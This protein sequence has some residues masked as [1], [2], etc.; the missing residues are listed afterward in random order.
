MQ[1]SRTRSRSWPIPWVPTVWDGKPTNN[2]MA[3]LG[4]SFI[5]NGQRDVTTDGYRSYGVA[6]GAA[7]DSGQV[8]RRLGFA[9]AFGNGGDD[10]LQAGVRLMPAIAACQGGVLYTYIG[11]NDEDSQLTVEQTIAE[12]K[13]WKQAAYDARTVIIFHTIAP[14]GNDTFPG[15]RLA[16]D[17]I[18]RMLERNARILSELPGIGAYVVDLNDLLLKPATAFDLI[19][20]YSPQDGK[21]P[22]NAWVQEVSGPRDGALL[23]Q[24]F[25]GGA[26]DAPTG[27]TAASFNTNVE[28]LGAS[29]SGGATL[30]TGYTNAKATGTTGTTLDYKEVTTATGRWCQITIGGTTATANAAVDLLRQIGLQNKLVTGRTSEGIIEY[31][32]DA[33]MAN[34][35]AIQLG[36][37]EFGSSTAQ[38]WDNNR[39]STQVVSGQARAGRMRTS[40][41]T[42]IDGITDHRFRLSA[43]LSTAGPPSG[44]IRVRMMENREIPG[45]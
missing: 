34:I 23:K 25:P 39:Y 31:E 29:T 11:T 36:T 40:P 41:F 3:E 22:G 18:T 13:R 33:G 19:D 1:R 10:T 9:G 38:N 14:R 8:V 43:Y 21:H 24:I 26:V 44:V 27:T 45:S 16:A 35:L 6:T 32:Y 28:I 4:H 20:A 15:A 2:K 37:Q 42:S 12:L 30:P 5:A 7:D 17:Q